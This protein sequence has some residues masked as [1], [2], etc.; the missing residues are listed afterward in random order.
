T[1]AWRLLKK[2][3]KFALDEMN[4]MKPEKILDIGAGPG[5]LS[6]MVAKKFP[7]A[8]FFTIDPSEY[9]VKAEIKNFEKENIKAQCK[10]GSSRDI[11]FGENFDLIYTSLSFHHWKERDSNIKYVLSKLNDNGT[12]MIIEFLQDYYK[13]PLSLTRKHSISKQYAESLK[14]DGFEKTVNTSGKFISI[15]FKKVS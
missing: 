2:L 13:S 7:D 15:K 6:I 1:I 9:M 4:S 3:Y 10:P 12:F 5:K 14:F 8:K 11:P